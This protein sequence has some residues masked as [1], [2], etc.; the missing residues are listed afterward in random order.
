MAHRSEQHNYTVFIEQHVYAQVIII[1]VYN[2][3]KILWLN[4][5]RYSF[6]VQSIHVSATNLYNHIKYIPFAPS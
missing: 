2:R 6:N 3:Y 4:S 1:Y 5:I